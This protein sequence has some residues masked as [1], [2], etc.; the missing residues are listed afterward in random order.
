VAEE[1][2]AEVPP[3]V[4]LPSETLLFSVS[5]HDPLAQVGF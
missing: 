3:E 4:E 2:E 5:C 1:E